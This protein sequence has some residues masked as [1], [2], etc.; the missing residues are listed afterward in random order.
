[1]AG[2]REH[3]ETSQSNSGTRP[4]LPPLKIPLLTLREFHTYVPGLSSHHG[5]QRND[6]WEARR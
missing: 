6:P 4:T 1:M 3:I 2:R 5:H